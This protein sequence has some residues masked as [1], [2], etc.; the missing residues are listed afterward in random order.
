MKSK[1][2]SQGFSIV[3]VVVSALI[4]MIVAAGTFA[5]FSMARSKSV[6]SEDELTA[7]NFARRY[8]QSLRPLV[9]QG[10]PFPLDCDNAL[11]DLI[12]AELGEQTG[13]Y[14]CDNTLVGGAHQVT[15]TISW[16]E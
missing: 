6:T 8:L 2:S 1:N 7:I 3:E 13:Q 9:E 5:V 14:R 15:L 4:F 16:D 11:H 12:D 10:T